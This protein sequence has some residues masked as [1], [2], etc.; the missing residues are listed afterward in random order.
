MVSFCG[1]EKQRNFCDNLSII[2]ANFIAYLFEMIKIRN[3]KSLLY[4]AGERQE[5][6]S[7][8]VSVVSRWVTV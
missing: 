4:N 3:R 6:G 8:A 7:L 5:K 2:Y 1:R